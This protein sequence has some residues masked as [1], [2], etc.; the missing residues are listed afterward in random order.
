MK[1]QDC[2]EVDGVK[3]IL[4]DA[5]AEMLQKSKLTMYRYLRHDYAGM[6]MRHLKR[7]ATYIA[8]EDVRSFSPLPAGNPKDKLFKSSPAW[9]AGEKRRRKNAKR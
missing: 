7:G 9:K 6:K 8:L 2:I 1:R 4:I 5:A 3:Y